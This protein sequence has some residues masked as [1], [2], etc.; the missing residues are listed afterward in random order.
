MAATR[1]REATLKNYKDKILVVDDEKMIR[2]SLGEA[3]RGWGFEPIEAET[4]SGA[5][6]AFEAES[7]AAVLL[8]INL[9]DGSGL[10]VLR[11][12]RQ[13]E[14]DAVIIMITANVLVDET[15]AALRG[16]AYDFIGKPI[17]L[18]EL[19][20]AIRNGIEASR[21]R[22]EVNQIR[23]ERSQQ[24]SFDQIIGQSPAIREMLSMAQK[25]AESEV[26]SVLLQGESGTGKDLVAKAI[27]Y[28]SNRADGPFVAINCAA[29]PGTLIESEL[30]GYEKGAFTDA[31][32][33]KEGMF[34]QAEGGTLLLDEIGE[35]ELSLQAKLLRVLEEGTFRRVGG[36]KDIPF[37]ARIIAAS[38][39]DLRRESEVNRFRLD[40][41]YRLSVI[42]IDIP[43]LRERGDDVLLLAEHY[44]QAFGE[45][46]RKQIQGF[47]PPVA[48]AFRRYRWPGNVRELR[49]VIER[50][51]ILEDENVITMKY[52]PRPVSG[53][54]SSDHASHDGRGAEPFH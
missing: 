24:F 9:P 15:I 2:W 1:K 27:H 40:L 12:M 34:E 3:L 6:A 5:L 4:G 18:E 49:N 23:R 25:V 13:R 19:H 10:D 52:I 41:Y 30:F 28:H 46:L 21:L 11:K 7:P 43:S 37:D 51:M 32:A 8:D 50:A 54:P 14:P 29:I 33:R 39:R 20:V 16:G 44:L 42:Q 17:N 48:S 36:L 38:N 35:L 45:R 26:S 53:G 31:K 47:D 22:Q